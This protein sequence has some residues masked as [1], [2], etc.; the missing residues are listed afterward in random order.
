[1]NSN[2]QYCFKTITKGSHRINSLSRLMQCLLWFEC[3]WH[4]GWWRLEEKHF[5]RPGRPP[6][7]RRSPP[8]QSRAVRAT[9]RALR[10]LYWP[11]SKGLIGPFGRTQGIPHCPLGSQGGP[12]VWVIDDCFATGA[13]KRRVSYWLGTRRI[14]HVSNDLEPI[15]R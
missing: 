14:N 5:H 2:D 9:D 10:N 1:M 8:D 3:Y 6:E 4:L 11:F 7:C 15:D 13:C 12:G